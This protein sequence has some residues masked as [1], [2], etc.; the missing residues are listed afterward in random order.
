MQ[1]PHCTRCGR[2]HYRFVACAN[3]D[4]WNEKHSEKVAKAAGPRVENWSVPAGF[5]E[6]N[7][8]KP[9]NASIRNLPAPAGFRPRGMSNGPEAA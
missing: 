3:V 8:S 4:D 6:L 7:P 5:R 1:V 2:E 9:N